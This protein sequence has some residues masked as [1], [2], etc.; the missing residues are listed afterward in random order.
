MRVIECSYERENSAPGWEM[1]VEKLQEPTGGFKRVR[2]RRYLVGRG[3]NPGTAQATVCS[4]GSVA[5]I[6]G[7]RVAVSVFRRRSPV[8]YVAS[9]EGH[10]MIWV[11]PGVRSTG[12]IS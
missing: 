8:S 1:V 9:T 4:C 5:R 12:Q 11:L 2:G 10:L 6:A 7:K 3:E